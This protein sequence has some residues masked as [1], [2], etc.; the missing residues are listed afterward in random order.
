[1]VSNRWQYLHQK[2]NGVTTERCLSAVRSDAYT[3]SVAQT[4]YTDTGHKRA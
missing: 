1:M 2:C 3:E 4:W